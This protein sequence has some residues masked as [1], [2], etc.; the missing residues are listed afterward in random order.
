M[1]SRSYNWKI[2]RRKIILLK[3]KRT[4]L[5]LKGFFNQ[6]ISKSESNQLREKMNNLLDKKNGEYKF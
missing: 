5:Y 4:K 2:K 6:L 3:N 1:Q